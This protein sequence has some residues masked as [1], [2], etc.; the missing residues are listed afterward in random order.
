MEKSEETEKFISDLKNEFPLVFSEGQ[1]T[2]IEDS[3]KLK[4]NIRPVFKAKMNVPFLALD[5]VNQE[6]E[7]LE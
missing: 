7:R 2:K 3:F 4:D 6:L 1:C 5:S